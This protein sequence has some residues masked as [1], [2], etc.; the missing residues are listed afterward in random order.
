VL[1]LENRVASMRQEFFFERDRCPATLSAF[2]RSAGCWMLDASDDGG[3]AQE[4]GARMIVRRS[5]R[6]GANLKHHT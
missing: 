2:Q 3:L 5:A 6:L 1:W 4:M